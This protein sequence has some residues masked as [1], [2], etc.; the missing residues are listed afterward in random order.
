M[1]TFDLSSRV[2][3]LF[4]PVLT[5]L[6]YL[7]DNPW[8]NAIDRAKSAGC[9]LA[10]VLIQR[11]L[12]VRPIIFIGFSL[13]ARAPFYALLELAKRKKFGIVQDVFL[14]DATLSVSQKKLVLWFLGDT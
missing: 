11:H 7:I 13:G 5:K 3:N 4:S 10:D 9:V 12:G 14:L 6:G 8:S 1:F 2:H